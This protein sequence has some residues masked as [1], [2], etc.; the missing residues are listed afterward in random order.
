M[1]ERMLLI[2]LSHFAVMSII[3]GAVLLLNSIKSKRP[4]GLK[5]DLSKKLE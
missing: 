2:L 1:T 5:N 4:P 3:M